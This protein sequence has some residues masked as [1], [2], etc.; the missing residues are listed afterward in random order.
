LLQCKKESSWRNIE[1]LVLKES[2]SLACHTYLIE[3]N[4]INDETCHGDDKN[5]SCVSRADSGYDSLQS[6]TNHDDIH[7]CE[8]LLSQTTHDVGLCCD[9]QPAGVN[10]T[11]SLLVGV[12][13]VSMTSSTNFVDDSS[14][15]KT[16]VSSRPS[17]E[18]DIAGS[19]CSLRP[20][21]LLVNPVDFVRTYQQLLRDLQS[22]RT[23]N[24]S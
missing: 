18:K 3:L 12:N 15:L 14:Q 4:N 11:P 19:N 23:S 7:G 8:F 9:T 13:N 21:T 10:S 17:I 5:S 20:P 6:E 1:S 24:V 2:Y 22:V 16:V